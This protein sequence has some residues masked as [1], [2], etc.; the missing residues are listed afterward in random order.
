MGC[1]RAVHAHEEAFES[2]KR[3][4]SRLLGA[5]WRTARATWRQLQDEPNAVAAD[6]KGLLGPYP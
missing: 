5:G 1:R 3:R 6:L 4:D 2:D